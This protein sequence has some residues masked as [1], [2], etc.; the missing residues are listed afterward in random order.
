MPGKYGGGREVIFS[1][2]RGHR[3]DG[4]VAWEEVHASPIPGPGG[5]PMHVVEVWRDITNRR[6]A[7]A[8]LAESHRLASLGLLASGFS[9]EMNTPLATVLTCVEG[10][11]RDLTADEREKLTMRLLRGLLECITFAVIRHTSESIGAEAVRITLKRMIADGEIAD[12]LITLAVE[13][14]HSEKFPRQQ[15]FNLV[16]DAKKFP[17]ATMILQRM[18]WE[19]FLLYPS[20]HDLRRQ[21]CAKLGIREDVRM[22]TASRDKGPK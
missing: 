19:H 10:I 1:V 18:V 3:D 16:S 12:K 7:E 21:V 15:I 2:R 20:K 5:T 9:H 14:D 13:L 8:R 22:L 6:A 11:A 4:S 17:F